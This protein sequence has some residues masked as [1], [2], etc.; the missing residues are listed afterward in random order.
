MPSHK[1]LN[2]NVKS[3]RLDTTPEAERSSGTVGVGDDGFRT[4]SQISGGRGIERAL[5][6]AGPTWTSEGDCG[7]G[8]GGD[9]PAT[10]TLVEAGRKGADALNW[11]AAAARKGR[12]HAVYRRRWRGGEW[13]QGGE[14]GGLDGSIGDWDQFSANEKK[15]GIKASFDEN[16]YTTKLDVSSIDASRRAEAERIAREIDSTSSTNMHVAEERNQAIAGDYDEEDRYSGVLT[17][18][19]KARPIVSSP[20]TAAPVVF[21]DEKKA[22]VVGKVMNYAE[23]AQSA[24]KK[25]TAE[26]TLKPAAAARVLG[27][28]LHVSK[29]VEKAAAAANEASS[30]QPVTWQPIKVTSEEEKSMLQADHEKD[31][32]INEGDV[33]KDKSEKHEKKATT[34]S[35]LKLNPLKVDGGKVGLLECGLVSCCEYHSLSSSPPISCIYGL[36][37]F[38]L[39]LS[40][41]VFFVSDDGNRGRSTR[42]DGH[43][44][45]EGRREESRSLLREC[46]HC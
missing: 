12:G 45:A 36:T 24:A 4:D 20:A 29:D 32:P 31:A 28:I 38:R 5:V 35:K 19:L 34:F 6:K 11:R 46:H 3:M 39:T 9:A 25:G 43:L 40:F 27:S 10:K 15:F 18:D 21:K 2:V 13:P 33:K 23:V 42:F 17:K 16:L 1:V 26:M 41:L 22:A 7:G 44:K 14:G 8:L 37:K 30:S